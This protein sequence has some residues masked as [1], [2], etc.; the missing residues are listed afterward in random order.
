VSRSKPHKLSLFL[1]TRDFHEAKYL[2]RQFYELFGEERFDEEKFASSTFFKSP[3]DG[4]C[5][6]GIYSALSQICVLL[7]SNF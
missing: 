7:K 2:G 4:K 6:P 1:V 3:C 5:F